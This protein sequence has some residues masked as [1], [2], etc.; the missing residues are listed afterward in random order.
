[1]VRR[2]PGR[3]SRAKPSE[4]SRAIRGKAVTHETADDQTHFGHPRRRSFVGAHHRRY[5]A[6][7]I[8]AMWAASE[9]GDTATVADVI[10]M[11]RQAGLKPPEPP[12]EQARAELA[13]ARQILWLDH[14]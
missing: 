12:P 5:A 6:G 9:P 13:R 7:E 10:V 3:R 4:K 11:L 1:M 2:D 14:A 8:S